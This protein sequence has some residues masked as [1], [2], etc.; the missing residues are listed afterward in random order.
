MSLE[1]GR[2]P[3]QVAD[4]CW[5]ITLPDPYPPGVVAV[6]L[7]ETGDA[8][9]LLDAG[10]PGDE[11]AAALERGL[12]RLGLDRADAGGVVLSHHHLDH[13]GGLA[14]G[15]AVPPLVTHAATARRLGEDR[16]GG[17][18]RAEDLLRRAGV[19]AGE[20]ELLRRYR[21]PDPPDGFREIA[22]DRR[23]EGDEGPLEGASGWRWIRVRGHAPG[24]LL[25]H[26]PSDGTMLS[27]DQFMDRLK[28]PLALGDP[29]ADPWGAYLRSLDRAA[30]AGPATMFPAHTGAIEP[31]GPWLERRRRSMGRTLERMASTVAEGAETA[32]EVAGSV[33]SRDPA[34]GQKALL[35][36]ETLAGLRRLGATGEARRRLEEGVERYRPA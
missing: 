22:V 21:E 10:P 23:L 20:R 19:P 34:P 14:A 29:D 11:A 1:S 27:F 7:L 18:E 30:E 17:A 5:R 24:H 25:V 15:D 3:E 26:R 36:R 28:T 9:L 33:F 32:W 16:R 4:G 13:A 2:P 6:Y 12:A 35:V 31:A 8:P